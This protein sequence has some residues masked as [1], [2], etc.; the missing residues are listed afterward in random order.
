MD[1]TSPCQKVINKILIPK[2]SERDYSAQEVAQ[3]L[4]SWPLYKSTRDFVILSIHGDDWDNL[5]VND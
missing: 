1:E 4:M 2:I 5:K 3:M